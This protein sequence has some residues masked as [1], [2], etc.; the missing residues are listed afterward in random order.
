[1]SAL[2]VNQQ[3][4]FS[5]LFCCI[6]H[7]H[8]IALYCLF[9]WY[10]SLPRRNK[11]Y[12]F[13]WHWSHKHTDDDE[14]HASSASPSTN[15]K[16]HAAASQQEDHTQRGTTKCHNF[17]SHHRAPPKPQQLSSSIILG[18]QETARRTGEAARKSSC[19][20]SRGGESSFIHFV[21]CLPC[22]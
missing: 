21:Q 22:R 19:H 12:R 5:F 11:S 14:W 6:I 3:K 2:K 17:I 1:M 7:T 20:G 8:T 16:C 15:R 9:H 10:C 18:T 4:T 13:L